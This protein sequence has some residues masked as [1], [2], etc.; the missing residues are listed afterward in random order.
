MKKIAI[1]ATGGTIAGASTGPINSVYESAKFGIN[2]ILSEFNELKSI[3][4]IS[5]EQICNIGSQDM[6]EKIWLKLSH[7]ANE[8]LANDKID[9]LVITHGTDT[10]EESGYFLTLTIK[11][12]KPVVITAAMRSANSLSS[13]GAMNLYNAISVAACKNSANMGVLVVINDE[14]HLARE[15]I[16]TNT[17][18][19]NAFASPNCGKC[20]IVHYGKVVFYTKSLRRH[21]MWSEFSAKF[22]KDLS[23]LQNLPCVEIVYDYAG[24]SGEAVYSALNLGAKGIICAALGNGNLSPNMLHALKF[25]N[26]KGAIVVI[27]SRTNSGIISGDELDFNKLNFILS[28][29]LNAQK[30]RVLLMLCIASGFDK[31]IIKEKFNIY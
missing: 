17:T 21:T 1:L 27:S 30:A 8:L 2:E 23:S 15:I 12:Q 20:G 29:S 5:A 16:K 11:S 14:I 22:C 28:D 13:D 10:L 18:A 4:D 6:N 3:A 26:S 25:A 9:A 31:E 19:L 7:R 24:A